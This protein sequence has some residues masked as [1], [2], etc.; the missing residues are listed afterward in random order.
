MPYTAIINKR[1]VEKINES[2]FQVSIDVVIND[3]VNDVIT[4]TFSERYFKDIAISTIESK[5]QKQIKKAWDE[6]IAEQSLLLNATFDTLVSTIQT[7]TN[8]YINK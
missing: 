4:K 5:L 7:S 8:T 2:D 6:Y 1:S 3:G